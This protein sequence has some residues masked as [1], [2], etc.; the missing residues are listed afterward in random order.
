MIPFTDP[1][2]FAVAHD[3]VRV[4]DKQTDVNGELS[5]NVG[6]AMV[7]ESVLNICR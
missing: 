2:K 5:G 4:R 6:R 7:Y 1:I 3:K